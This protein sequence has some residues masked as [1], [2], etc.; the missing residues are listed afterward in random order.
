MLQR[1]SAAPNALQPLLLY[2]PEPMRWSRAVAPRGHATGAEG[3]SWAGGSG[4]RSRLSKAA[5]VAALHAWTT[6]T[7]QRTDAC[8]ATTALL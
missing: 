4:G 2:A 8:R 3:G 7:A 6:R 1:S 5:A